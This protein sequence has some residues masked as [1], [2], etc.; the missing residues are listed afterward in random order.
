INMKNYKKIKAKYILELAN[1]PISAEVEKVIDKIIIP[2]VLAN[3]GG[4]IV[5]Y[6]EWL[7]NKNKEKWDK[8][9]VFKKLKD[10]INKEFEEIK[11]EKEKNNLTLKE[12]AYILAIKRLI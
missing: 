9:K 8:E 4:V 3:S 11:K 2:D 1:G 12:A 5:S 10:K 6:F 7:Q